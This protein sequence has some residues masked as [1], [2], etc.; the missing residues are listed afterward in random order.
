[1][2]KRYLFFDFY[3]NWSFPRLVSRGGFLVV[4]F[5]LARQYYFNMVN[6][7]E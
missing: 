4:G 2:N 3:I 7:G 6:Q 5:S 1:M